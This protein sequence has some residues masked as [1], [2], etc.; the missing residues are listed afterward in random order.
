MDAQDIKSY[1][2]LN[3]IFNLGESFDNILKDSFA[4]FSNINTGRGVY[5]L[6]D[7]KENKAKYTIDIE[8]PGTDKNDFIISI[9]KDN[10]IIQGEKKEE[11]KRKKNHTSAWNALMEVNQTQMA[12]KYNNGVLKITLPKTE[13]DKEVEVKIT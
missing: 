4:G 12:T 8:V 2:P 13:K 7:I 9:K 10:L 5:P 1:V 6:L 3:R 11:K